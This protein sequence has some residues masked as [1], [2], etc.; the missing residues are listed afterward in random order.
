MSHKSAKKD[1]KDSKRLSSTDEKIKELEE[2]LAKTKYNK[3]TQFHIGLVKAKIAKLKQKEETKKKGAKKGEGY[4]V[5]KTGDATVLFLGY[6]S[7]GKST[8][9]NALA[10]T[11]SKVAGYDFTT[12]TV[13]P[14][15]ARIKGADIQLLDV[16]GIV[17]GAAAGKGRGK[18]VLSVLQNADLVLIIIDIDHPEHYE[19][20]LNEIDQ[21]HIRLNQKKPNVIITKTVRGGI[22]VGTN[23]KL[24]K[25][26]Q[27]TVKA[28][29]REFKI[30]NADVLIR[31]D[32]SADQLI[33]VIEANKRYIPAVTIINKID[34]ADKQTIEKAKKEVNPDL[35]ISADKK[36]NIDKLRDLI[37]ERLEL[38][39]VYLKQVGKQADM[40]EPLIM[41]KGTRVVDV[42]DKLHK[43]FQ[44]RFRFARIW[45]PSARFDGQQFRKLDK[46]LQDEDVLELHLL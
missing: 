27:D 22:R 45:G 23:V 39:R 5:K 33:D 30:V 2:E 10:N 43:D 18:E 26:N 15:T 9:L 32:I 35:M 31:E 7:A 13:V 8:L 29:L 14:G 17:G 6:P 1:D 21:S 46:E 28:I 16:P 19:A 12:L 41:K 38:M 20:I 36:Q 34:I 4:A 44:K 11:E 24:T 3:K 40:K 25:L 37:F 42:C